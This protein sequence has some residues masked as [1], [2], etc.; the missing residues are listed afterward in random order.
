[1]FPPQQIAKRETQFA[2]QTASIDGGVSVLV[3]E[4]AQLTVLTATSGGDVEM[5]D[6]PADLE[7]PLDGCARCPQH[8]PGTLVDAGLMRLDQ[9]PQ[10]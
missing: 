7:Q 6:Q 4:P 3:F 8:Q 9:H 2:G 5:P 10:P 1:M